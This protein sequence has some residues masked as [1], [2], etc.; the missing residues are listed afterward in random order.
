MASSAFRKAFLIAAAF[1]LA[2]LV[3]FALPEARPAFMAAAAV[4]AVFL[5]RKDPPSL[6]ALTVIEMVIGSHGHMLFVEAGGERFTIRMLLFAI[7]IAGWALR[8]PRAVRGPLTLPLAAVAAAVLWG[9]IRGLF[10]GKGMGA[11]ASDANAYAFILLIPIALDLIRGREALARLAEIF[12]G[13]LL[14]LSLKSLTLLYFFSHDFG[15]L[16]DGLF[17]WQR[18]FW[19]AEIT[20]LGGGGWHRVFAASSVFLIPGV[21]AGFMLWRQSR[22][23]K[24]FVWLV[25]CSAALVLS[26]S[27]SFALGMLS[28]VPASAPF[29]AR[30]KSAALRR[31]PGNIFSAAAAAAAAVLLLAAVAVFPAP[32]PLGLGVGAFAERLSA[33]DP[34]VSSRWNVLPPLASAIAEAPILGSGFGS[35]VTYRSDDPRIISLHPGGVITTG[36]VEW[37]YLEI[38]LKTG[39]FGLIAVGWLFLAAG[40]ETLRALNECGEV[41]YPFA[42]SAL[43]SFAAF[44]VLNIFTPYINHPLGWMYLALILAAS[45]R[46]RDSRS[47]MPPRPS[48]FSRPAGAAQ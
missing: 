2:S 21:L 27:R 35:T 23:R 29:L 5:A 40:R 18:A 7:L 44:L 11:V 48:R 10:T 39:I 4:L 36:A 43:M 13:A 12:A 9:V 19:L 22:N 34:A 16:L 6:F 17:K 28:A 31:I 47:G 26:F 25:A 46:L 8:A 30:R 20:Q 41:D 14:W 1:E 15:P 37:Q 42:A 38:W 32:K 33:S 3:S 24:A 45:R